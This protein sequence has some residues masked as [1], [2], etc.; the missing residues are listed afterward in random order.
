[1]EIENRKLKRQRDDHSSRI[2]S[3]EGDIVRIR[4]EHRSMGKMKVALMLLLVLAQVCI[5]VLLNMWLL[6]VFNGYLTFSFA[7]DI[8]TCFYVISSKKH[9]QSKAVWIFVI[10][11][12]FPIGFILY[13]ISDENI[14]FASS[15]KRYRQIVIKTSALAC[16]GVGEKT[17]S[18]G[19]RS[20]AHYLKAQ[21]GFVPYRNTRAKYF[22]SGAQVFDDMIERCAAAKKYIF[23][24]YFIFADGVLLSRFLNVLE[25]RAAAGVDVRIIYDD[26]G[27]DGR[28]S[29]KVKKRIRSAGIQL[30]A[31]NKLVPFYKIGMNYR[32]HRKITV[33]DG[34]TAYTGGINIADEYVN[35]KR[36]YGYWKDN[37]V[38]LDGDAVEGFVIMFLRQWEYV[39]K[40]KPDYAAFIA[41]P[42]EDKAD[43][44]AAD[45]EVVA[46]EEEVADGSH[47]AAEYGAPVFIPYAAGLEYAEPVA[48]DIYAGVIA[49]A[50]EKLYIMTPYF[51]P[52]ETTT[53]MLACRALAGVDVRIVLP[54]VPD[55]PYVYL[56]SLG[57]A[58]KLM[59]SGVKVYTMSDSFVHTKSVLTESCAVIGSV[60]FDLRSFFQQY[61]NALLTDDKTVLEGLSADFEDTFRNSVQR[62][63][64]VKK[65][66]LLRRII[67]GILQLFA[68]LM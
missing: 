1:M 11:V 46:E 9:G 27:S 39:T 21:G 62:N 56:I 28:V 54:S 51:V 8:V 13:F 10:L 41:P 49:S 67:T 48:R 57:N 60:N 37:G 4:A 38:R 58:D 18:A 2:K 22:P 65:P 47:E 14:F 40:N 44:T 64:I 45:G 31:F 6:D 32:D 25:E 43:G 55:K 34:E 30:Y 61:E 36:M 42:R 26:L 35:E 7:A 3:P 12:L 23:I 53:N 20:A 50:K 19:I 15:R 24:E 33:I 59:K 63:I 17:I 29:R 16:K 52:D 66:R 5:F 68:P